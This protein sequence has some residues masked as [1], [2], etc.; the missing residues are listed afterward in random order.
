MRGTKIKTNGGAVKAG[1]GGNSRTEA[2]RLC[3]EPFLAVM[4]LISL[5]K[6]PITRSTMLRILAP[7]THT[8]M[9]QKKSPQFE[10]GNVANVDLL[11][12]IPGLS[13]GRTAA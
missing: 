1:E 13:R 3:S 10:N 9:Q 11:K 5:S 2:K 8:R 6:R 4:A 12:V 7:C